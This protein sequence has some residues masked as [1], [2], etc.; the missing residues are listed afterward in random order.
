MIF[1][2]LKQ[3]SITLFLPIIL[4]LFDMENFFKEV[5][6]LGISNSKPADVCN[7]GECCD[8]VN[9]RSNNGIWH[10]CGMPEKIFESDDK[11]FICKFVHCN[12][13][14]SH[15]ISYDG[16]NIFWEASFENG[17]WISVNKI[18]AKI[19]NVTSFKSM[20]NIL[21]AVCGN[22]F[23]YMI[24]NENS[25]SLI[26]EINMPLLQFKFQVPIIDSHSNAKIYEL[27]YSMENIEKELN[28]IYIANKFYNEIITE[29]N[30]INNRNNTFS[31]PVWVRYA[32][33][34][35]DGSYI[36]PSSPILM[37]P[38]NNIRDLYKTT[39]I[40]SYN[41]DK[42]K[43]SVVNPNISFKGYPLYFDTLNLPSSDWD[44][45]ISS[46]DI[47]ISK[48]LFIGSENGYNVL[49]K[50]EHY[51]KGND[52]Y[53]TYYVDL[54]FPT[55]SDKEIKENLLNETLFYKVASYK[56]SELR[57]D[58]DNAKPINPSFTL[59]GLTS[60]EILHIDNSSH[61]NFT[62]DISFLYNSR[63]HIGN[64]R[65]C[66]PKPFDITT[67]VAPL[68]KFNGYES[69][70]SFKD[71][72]SC[73]IKVTVKSGTGDKYVEYNSAIPK[74][75][76]LTPFISY[77]DSRASQMEIWLNYSDGRKLYKLLPLTGSKV[78][79]MAYFINDDYR[80]IS[81]EEFSGK[82]PTAKVSDYD[83][84]P[85]LLKVSNNENPFYF[86][87]ELSYSISNGKIL[88][89]AAVT[90]ELSQGRYGDFPLYIFTSDGIWALQQG[91][92]DVLYK[93][94]HP[95]SRDI[96][97]STKAVV[98]TDN[99]IV[100][101]SEKGL[102]ILNGSNVVQLSSF[103]LNRNDIVKESVVNGKDFDIIS[104]QEI[105][106]NFKTDIINSHIEFNYKN[107]ELLFLREGVNYLYSL[108]LNDG[109]WNRIKFQEKPLNCFLKIYPQL[110]ICDIE[111]GIYN[112]SK[113]I[114][115][116]SMPFLFSTRAIKCNNNCTFKHL[117][118]VNF[119]GELDF[120]DNNMR[121]EISASNYPDRGFSKISELSLKDSFRD[122]V[123]IPIYAPS[124][125]YFRVSGYGNA[126][127]GMNINNILLTYTLKYNSRVR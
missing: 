14:Y 51:E 120:I 100:F 2:P 11:N 10:V 22:G 25:Y 8:I 125:K 61:Y 41:D 31:S 37:M 19:E 18:I 97:L 26:G 67:F 70:S 116:V 66:L 44:N 84:F 111:G 59:E 83:N 79:N 122:G 35:F 75:G 77:P 92:D 105:I 87:Q 5:G 58:I 9:M 124:Y 29:I 89:F 16:Y 13:D 65:R 117:K 38:E 42:K 104:N 91:D 46:I 63:L 88:N 72:S 7:D 15:L 101:L 80:Y 12:D 112:L 76:F 119:K 24:F 108:S 102:M 69:K 96:A 110:Y 64:I 34:L 73:H 121:I 74:E 23:Q 98:N 60:Q 52:S 106:D 27:P 86:P 127:C 39:V 47:F 33:R 103:G 49:Y 48:P 43:G 20:G 6:L 40:I 90:T 57:E 1:L 50:N 3:N 81:F 56:L 118:E 30:D 53:S 32:I 78:E 99:D 36:K 114:D 45:I 93:S 28:Y 113:E 82:I 17:K 94:L 115:N 54:E 71:L 95:V 109:T 126:K 123:R 107:R 55:L 68:S 62:G 21:M 4:I 85:N